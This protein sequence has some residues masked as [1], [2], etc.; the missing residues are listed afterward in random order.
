MHPTIQHQTSSDRTTLHTR[1]IKVH[2]LWHCACYHPSHNLLPQSHSP[3]LASMLHASPSRR[4]HAPPARLHTRLPSTAARCLWH[5]PSKRVFSILRLSQPPPIPT[6][7]MHAFPS[8]ALPLVRTSASSPAL[9]DGI[10]ASNHFCVCKPSIHDWQRA[11]RAGEKR[12]ECGW[13]R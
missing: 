8:A 13:M 11:G 6:E 3:N 2:R 10:R 12:R 4:S 5:P 7:R 9:P 1:A